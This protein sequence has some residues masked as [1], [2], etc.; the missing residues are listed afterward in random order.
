MKSLRLFLLGA[1]CGAVSTSHAFSI[2][3][4]VRREDDGKRIFVL[5]KNSLEV[6]VLCGSVHVTVD[7]CNSNFCEMAAQVQL[8]YQQVYL[9]RGQ[10]QSF[11]L[12]ETIQAHQA[13]GNLL[14]NKIT[15]GTSDC[16]PA[17]F[18]D[19]LNAAEKTPEEDY[20]LRVIEAHL[21][22]PLNRT[23]ILQIKELN[24]DQSG[25]SNLRP[26][27]FFKALEVLSLGENKIVSLQALAQLEKLQT[28]KLDRNPELADLGPVLVLPQIKNIWARETK[29]I[30]VEGQPRSASLRQLVLEGKSKTCEISY[31][32]ARD[33]QRKTKPCALSG[34]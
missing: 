9:A 28:L 4:E 26:L 1:L 2:T 30:S 22:R 15:T 29:V 17:E 10:T 6:E 31:I 25:I 34:Y 32:D 33:H 20:T 21:K 8:G 23:D 12:T 7:F 19:Y 27:R 11:D 3:A 16:R 14:V 24:L 13:E 18:V 5:A